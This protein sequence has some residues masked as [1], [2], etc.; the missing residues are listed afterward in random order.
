MPLASLVRFIKRSNSSSLEGEGGTNPSGREEIGFCVCVVI[1][2]SLCFSSGPSPS[3]VP[4]PVPGP[5][6]LELDLLPLLLL[7]D[8]LYRRYD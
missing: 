5:R 1:S 2:L 8:G 7:I 6:I 4:S 3:P